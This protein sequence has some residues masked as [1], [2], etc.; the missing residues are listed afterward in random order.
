MRASSL[1]DCLTSLG[2][3][4]EFQQVEYI[5]TY[6]GHDDYLEK[7]CQSIFPDLKYD[8]IRT[9]DQDDICPSNIDG[10]MYPSYCNDGW[11][12]CDSTT[13]GCANPNFNGFF[14]KGIY[15]V[16]ILVKSTK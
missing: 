7:V 1:R 4:P 8:Q 14:C 10:L 3:D 16:Q 2:G 6:F 9:E 12:E 11:L 5:E 13:N 15:C